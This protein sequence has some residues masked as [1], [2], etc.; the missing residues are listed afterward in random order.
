MFFN[1]V[2]NRTK[3]RKNLFLPRNFIP[4]KFNRLS[5]RGQEDGAMLP[6]RFLPTIFFEC[7]VYDRFFYS[8][9]LSVTNLSI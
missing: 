7:L 1:H 9:L 2:V 8:I 5:R 4:K 6:S 3:E